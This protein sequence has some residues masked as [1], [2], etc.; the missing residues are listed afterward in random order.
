[1]ENKKIFSLLLLVVFL[2]AVIS[3][4]LA[5]NAGEKEVPDNFSNNAKTISFCG[6]EGEKIGAAGMPSKCCAGLTPL[7][8]WPN[9]YKDDCSNPQPPTG[10]ST[11]ANY[12]DGIC[13]NNFEGKCNCPKDCSGSV[14]GEEGETLS[15]KIDR[16]CS[17]LKP[18]SLSKN[19]NFGGLSS[20]EKE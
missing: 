14:C 5:E 7:S 15:G 11:C 4:F 6:K 8:G 20:C 3:I 17:E 10:L 2:I 16:C 13:N 12:G 9:G 18:K 19:G 1:M